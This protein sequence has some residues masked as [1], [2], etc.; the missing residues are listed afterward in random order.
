M[1][2]AVNQAAESAGVVGTLG[3]NGKLFVAQLVN[4]SVVLFVMWK[5]VYK[6]LVRMLD[7]RAKKIEQGL[8]DAEASASAK[9]AAQNEKDAV[10]LDARKQAKVILEQAMADAE[11]QRVEAVGRAKQEVERV[12]LLGKEN[13]RA[14]REKLVADVK[15]ELADLVV[16]AAERVLREKIDAKKDE[17][18]IKESVKEAVMRL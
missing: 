14:E 5:W 12:V 2:E 15:A 11:K 6:P 10:V 13:I 17:K 18:L 16:L 4:F 8:R 3:L 7:E 9:Q 1:V